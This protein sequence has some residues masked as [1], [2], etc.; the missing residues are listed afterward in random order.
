MIKHLPWN[1]VPSALLREKLPLLKW[2]RLEGG[3]TARDTAALML[4]VA[5]IFRQEEQ[6]FE[7]VVRK[8]ADVSYDGL[9]DSTGLSRGLISQGLKRLVELGL[10]VQHGSLQKRFYE[11]QW[12]TTGAWFKLPCRAVMKKGVITPFLAFTLR[13]KHELNALKLYLYLASARDNSLPYTVS[14][15]ETIYKYIDVQERDIR[16][17]ISVL[18]AAGLLR[19]VARFDTGNN[20]SLGANHYYLAGDN[21]LFWAKRAE[22][23]T[24]TEQPAAV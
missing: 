24:G 5:M 18:I 11:L 2:G 10:I 4:Y 8:I 1:Q 6:E 3:S 13:S 9:S 14:S 15:Y 16:K 23:A 7:N 22:L 19:N 21:D 17:A 12:G 20:T